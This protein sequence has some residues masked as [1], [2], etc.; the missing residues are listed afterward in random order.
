[1]S[2]E[3]KSSFSKVTTWNTKEHKCQFYLVWLFFS[4]LHCFW[5]MNKGRW[6]RRSMA[7]SSGN[8]PC[9][10]FYFLL[11]FLLVRFHNSSK[12]K[13]RCDKKFQINFM[14]RIC[15]KCHCLS[16]GLLKVVYILVPNNTVTQIKQTFYRTVTQ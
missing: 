13:K 14:I 8:V 9:F 2:K 16:N 11:F 15:I 1:M 3:K 12:N 5:V 7:E 6:S 4:F 10:I